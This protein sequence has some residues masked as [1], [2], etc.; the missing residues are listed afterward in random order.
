LI[1]K[2]AW[3]GPLDKAALQGRRCVPGAIKETPGGKNRPQPVISRRID[4]LACQGFP[5]MRR[6]QGSL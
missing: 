3:P 6:N 4:I 5:I 1:N 2:P